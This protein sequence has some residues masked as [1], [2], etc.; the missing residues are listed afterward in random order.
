MEL[1]SGSLRAANL[2]FYK[3]PFNAVV[4]LH[5]GNQDHHIVALIAENAL[6]LT[7]GYLY[8]KKFCIWTKNPVQ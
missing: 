8:F 5:L 3:R 4:G 7:Y 1:T 2:E 6:K